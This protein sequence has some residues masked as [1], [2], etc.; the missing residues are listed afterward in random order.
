[1]D[2][3]WIYKPR[4]SEAYTDGVDAFLEFAFGNI[5]VEK[6]KCP[7]N[8]CS[9]YT[10]RTRIEIRDHLICYGFMKSYTNWVL[11][12]EEIELPEINNQLGGEIHTDPISRDESMTHL[13]NDLFPNITNHSTNGEVPPVDVDEPVNNNTDEPSTANHGVKF[14]EKLG[15]YCEELYPGCTKF[16]RL[17]FILKLYHIK[18]L[19]G[20][21]DKGISMVVELIKEAFPVAKLPDTFR[22][23]KKVIRN[24]GLSYQS[25]DVCPNHCML[26]WEENASREKCDVCQLS[27]WKE[28]TTGKKAGG[29]VPDTSGV[30]AGGDVPESSA[31]VN[32]KKEKKKRKIPAM[33]LRYFPLKP[34]LQR[35]FMSSKT[36]SDMTWHST[37]ANT[38]GK[39]RHPKDGKAWK[40][41][42]SRFPDFAADP[43]NVRL[44][45]ASDGF[46]PFGSM[47][48]SY[49][50]WPVILFAYNLPP[51]ISMNRTSMIMS[52]LIPGKKGP[53]NDIDVFLQP[54]IKELKELWSDGVSTLDASTKETFNMRA[55]VMWTV[56]D[57]PAFGALSGWNTYTTLACPSCNYDSVEHRLRFGG[58]NCFMGHR[59][60]LPL[61]HRFRQSKE[62]F[63][64][65][66][67]TRTP[68]PTP[69]GST[70][71]RQQENV[72]VTFGKKVD[73]AGKK[74]SRAEM[75]NSNDQQWKKKSI[76]LSC[77]IGS[78]ITCV[79]IWT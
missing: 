10:P 73:A 74:R 6:L 20:I 72:N 3:S 5:Q 34:R 64:G 71:K 63:D 41:F 56:N 59:R 57:F 76:F 30:P 75:E 12:G 51:W 54:L 31:S 21:S 15:E 58:K 43:R 4:L 47:S 36:A 19:C 46:N 50:I 16:T 55:A 17:S 22:D 42:D 69:S 9:L 52:M 39:I 79:T 35:L 66:V 7:C 37:A 32:Q 29:D 14:D 78:F 62:A 23:M 61:S 60:Y 44:G 13:L 33:I 27:R 24:L 28:S 70:I 8:R 49:S 45:L 40:S 18:C 48:L 38:D 67:E 25:I 53:G 68:P 11:H 65:T 77:L 26:Y 2:K 1:M